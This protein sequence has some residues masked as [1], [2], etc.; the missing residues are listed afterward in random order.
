MYQKSHN[1]SN[2]AIEIMLQASHDTGA[3]YG[4]S[5]CTEIIFEHGKI[6]RGEGIQVLEER[7]KTKEPDENKIYKFLR[8]EQ[9]D[10]IRTKTLSERVK[11]E[12]SKRVKML[13]KT[14]LS[15]VNLA[16]VTNMKVIPVEAYAMDICRFNVSEL[17]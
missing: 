16:K 13:A 1:A 6:V 8:I 7:M 15:D 3:C 5:K 14:E 17:K 10:D 11:E 9:T 12:V 2:N 4:V